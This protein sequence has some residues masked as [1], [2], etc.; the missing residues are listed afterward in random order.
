MAFTSSYPSREPTRAEFDQTQGVL[1]VEFGASWCGIC[2]AAQPAIAAAL[3][4]H[5]GV[6]HI[7]VGDG[8]GKPLGRSFRVKL[9]PTLIALRNGSEVARLVR[10]TSRQAIS[11]MLASAASSQTHV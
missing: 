9:W 5:A 6:E 8:P 11:Q 7:K 3:G 4:E 1:L 2:Q 10:P